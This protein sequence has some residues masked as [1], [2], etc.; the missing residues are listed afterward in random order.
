MNRRCALTLPQQNSLTDPPLWLSGTPR[1]TAPLS[2]RSQRPRGA[3]RSRAAC[4]SSCPKGA[5]WLP[6]ITKMHTPIS[7][8]ASR[9]RPFPRTCRSKTLPALCSKP[10]TTP[11]GAR[12]TKSRWACLPPGSPGPARARTP[13]ATP[14]RTV[15]T[16]SA[17]SPRSTTRPAQLRSLTSSTPSTGSPTGWTAWARPSTRTVCLETGNARRPKMVHGPVTT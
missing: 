6:S 9:R 4:W 5:G 17:I 12:Q 7:P 10:P 2:S 16:R 13:T 1:P 14:P 3:T 15:T 8:R 11:P